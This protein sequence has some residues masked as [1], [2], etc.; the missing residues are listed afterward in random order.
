MCTLPFH[1]K[2]AC[3]FVEKCKILLI[4]SAKLSDYITISVDGCGNN[5]LLG[6]FCAFSGGSICGN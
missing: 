4:S 2:S 3:C 5:T 1:I 6:S